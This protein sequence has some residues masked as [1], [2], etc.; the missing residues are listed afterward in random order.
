MA[1]SILHREFHSLLWVSLGLLTTGFGLL[2]VSVALDHP[3][4]GGLVVIGIVALLVG[5][6]AEGIHRMNCIELTRDRLRVG[7]DSFVR[8][9]ID[10][11][12]GVQPSL[13]LAPE[14]QARVESEIPLPPD[15][16]IRVAGGGWGRR[17]G[18]HMVVLREAESLRLLAVFTRHP[19]RLDRLLSAWVGE[20]PDRPPD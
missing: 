8:A 19:R 6:M 15:A 11:L 4:G 14:E 18:T 3:L 12:F 9:D 2:V 13:V 20:V 10:G 16:D 17:L 5:A 7:R 1:G